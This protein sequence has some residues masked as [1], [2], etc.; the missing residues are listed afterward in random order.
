MYIPQAFEIT[1]E[2]EIFSFIEAN[3]FGQLVSI[4]SGEL[5]STH[6]PF[7]LS[8]DKTRI[9][10]HL[11]KQ[12]P[13]HLDIE[14][15]SVM[16]TL[17]GPHDY[18]SPSWY[19]SPGVPTWNYQSVHLYGSC[20]VLFEPEEIRT[21]VD[22]L[23]RKYESGFESPW[24]P[25]YRDSRLGAIVGLEIS[26]D[27]MQCKYKLSQNR[28]AEDRAEVISQLELSGANSLAAQMRRNEPG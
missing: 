28:P 20:K 27:R 11:A 13:Q 1:D 24:L 25:E 9:L 3:A 2:Q 14:N 15:Q 17:D 22:T 12:N 6:M 8:D 26:I 23:T 7:L 5:C 10:G 16:V 18:I 19:H 21:I 4:S